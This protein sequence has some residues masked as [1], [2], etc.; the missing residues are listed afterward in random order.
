[1]DLEI[2]SR[3]IIVMT[4]VTFTRQAMIPIL[5]ILHALLIILLL[6]FSQD[7]NLSIHLL[8]DIYIWKDLST[9]SGKFP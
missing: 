6:Y 2:F 9:I 4:Q 7:E 3:M 5:L 1:M 8:N